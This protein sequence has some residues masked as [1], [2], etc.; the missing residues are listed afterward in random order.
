MNKKQIN[1]I[2]N[3]LNIYYVELANFDELISFSHT[4]LK[5]RVYEG[6]EKDNIEEFPFLLTQEFM[7]VGNTL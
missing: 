1:Y 5:F 3:K 2:Y 7:L 4:Y 6:L